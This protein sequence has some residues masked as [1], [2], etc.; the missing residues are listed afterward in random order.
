[1]S[2]RACRTSTVLLIVLA[3]L[4]AVS[5]E[6]AERHAMSGKYASK[7]A[8]LINI[9][10]RGA[11][12]CSSLVERSN[13]Y[14]FGATSTPVLATPPITFWVAFPGPPAVNPHPVQAAG[15]CVPAAAPV[16]SSVGGAAVFGGGAAKSFTIPVGAFQLPLPVPPALNVVPVPVM[17]VQQL[18]TSWGVSGP[19]PVSVIT[20]GPDARTNASFFTTDGNGNNNLAPW[21]QFG[22]NAWQNQ[23]GRAGANFT[24]CWNR[25]A[26]GPPITAKCNNIAG[27]TQNMM[28]RYTGGGNAFG[29][30]IA[31]LLTLGPN[32]GSVAVRSGSGIPVG[33]LLLNPLASSG[34]GVGARGYLATRVAVGG[35]APVFTK[36]MTAPGM[37]GTLAGSGVVTAVTGFVG[38]FPIAAQTNMPLPHTTGTVFVRRTG[39]NPGGAVSVNTHTAMG[40]DNRNA[41][42]SGNI[43]LVSGA[44]AVSPGAK[45]PAIDI[46]SLNFVPEP[47]AALMLLAGGMGLVGLDRLR[48][49][50][51]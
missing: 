16:I 11:T 6:A 48:R 3:L 20:N 4:F 42:G 1:M 8:S 2:I 40:A 28:A 50:R 13:V 47:G 38:S 49:R 9:P 45:T 41:A 21:R 10:N 27:G 22:P 37:T 34:S 43:I 23:T 26:T 25:F 5:A 19:V 44:M 14:N 35:L 31:M 24:V 15:S 39:Y 17:A 51:S 12:P 36:F 7:R 30:T 29:G 18:A 46:M 32:P 33:G